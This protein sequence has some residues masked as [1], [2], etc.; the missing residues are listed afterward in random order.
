MTTFGDF[1]KFLEILGFFTATLY[2]RLMVQSKKIG[3]LVTWNTSHENNWGRGV[4][5]F[6]RTGADSEVVQVIQLNPLK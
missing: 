3:F 1:L 2:Y 6:Q 5:S 4:V